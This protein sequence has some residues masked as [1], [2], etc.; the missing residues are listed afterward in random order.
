MRPPLFRNFNSVGLDSLTD[1]SEQPLAPI[2]IVI[3]LK[4]GP[5]GFPEMS[6]TNYQYTLRKIPEELKSEHELNL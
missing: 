3:P 1:V 5:I 6:V 2:F 4:M